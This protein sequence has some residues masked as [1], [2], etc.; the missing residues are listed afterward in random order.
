M[1]EDKFALGNKIARRQF[2]WR[3]NFAIVKFL[4]RESILH[5][6]HFLHESKQRTVKNN[7]KKKNSYRLIKK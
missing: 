5:E 2:A 7:K 4:H 6:G 3:V 1:D